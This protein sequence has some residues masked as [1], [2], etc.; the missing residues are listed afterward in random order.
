MEL[1]DQT[2]PDSPLVRIAVGPKLLAVAVVSVVAGIYDRWPVAIGVAVLT[3]VLYAFARIPPRAVWRSLRGLWIL[4]ALLIAFQALHGAPLDGARQALRMV[5]LIALAGLVTATT[6]FA[7]MVAFAQRALAPLRRFGADPEAVALAFGM[8]LRFVPLLAAA[9]AEAADA[10]RARGVRPWPWRLV[11]PV[12]RRTL[13]LS[14][15]VAVALAA[16]EPPGP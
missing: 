8:V 5:A 10:F 7:E 13:L 12:V 1:I 15:D 14:D 6:P 2:P 4:A 16:R 9:A 11:L 3:G